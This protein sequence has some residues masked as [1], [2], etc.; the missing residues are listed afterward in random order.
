MILIYLTLYEFCMN[1][2]PLFQVM[3]KMQE[4]GGDQESFAAND[5][6][7]EATRDFSVEDL[8]LLK[9][10]FLQFEQVCCKLA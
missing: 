3:Q 2:F 5:P 8:Y 4:S 6:G 9:T 1:F 7:A 10:L